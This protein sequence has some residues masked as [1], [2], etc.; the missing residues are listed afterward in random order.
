MD[1]EVMTHPGQLPSPVS[2]GST[3]RRIVLDLLDHIGSKWTVLIVGALSDGPLR[4]SAI[5]RSVPGISQRMLTF[6][7]RTLE[8][9]GL[10]DRRAFATIPPRVE[11]RLTAFGLSLV[12]P[13][14]ALANWAQESKDG[15]REARRRH[16][17]EQAVTTGQNDS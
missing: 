5:Q 12:G 1:G 16:D 15:V 14:R 9:N 13:V 7:L 6:T 10:V 4:F 3:D 8:R 2:T 17:R 11:Y